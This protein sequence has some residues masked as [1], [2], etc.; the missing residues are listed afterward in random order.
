MVSG[1]EILFYQQIQ[2]LVTFKCTMTPTSI[3]YIYFQ[4]SEQKLYSRL[5]HWLIL[6]FYENSGRTVKLNGDTIAQLR[7]NTHVTQ[8][9]D[10]LISTKVSSRSAPHEDALIAALE[11]LDLP[12]DSQVTVTRP[13]ADV[14]Q[15][16]LQDIYRIKSGLP[17]I[18]TPLCFWAPGQPFPFSLRRDNYGGI[19]LNT[20]TVVST[21]ANI[22]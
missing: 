19:V 22:S 6:T 10:T 12:L 3:F 11:P 15:V 1:A 17:L 5:H 20:A 4:A 21:L 8:S 18:F 2:I 7:N 9:D 14:N 16:L 13:G